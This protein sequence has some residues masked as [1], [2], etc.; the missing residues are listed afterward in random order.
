MRALVNHITGENLWIAAVL[1]GATIASVGDSLDGDL[2]G[3][4]PA[5]MYL[6]TVAQAKAAF[7]PERLVAHYGVSFGD[8]SGYD[9]ASQLFMDQLV[10]SWDVLMGSRQQVVL[11]EGLL[12]AAIP[13][14]QEM[15]AFVGQGS[16]FGNTL[17]LESSPSNLEILVGTVGRSLAW[18]APEGA[19]FK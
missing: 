16:V 7:S 15:V 12:V 14:A 11:D 2:V 17:N 1:G 8:I 19:T 6:S 18:K 5:A 3:D 13:V 10:H 9:Y 4:D